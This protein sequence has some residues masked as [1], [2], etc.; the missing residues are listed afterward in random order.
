METSSI[1]MLICGVVLLYGGLGF[2]ISAAVKSEKRK[3][4]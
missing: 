1:I 3:K 4:K 2:C